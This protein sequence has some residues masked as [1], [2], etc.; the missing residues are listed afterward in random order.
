MT[1]LRIIPET[2]AIQF[3]GAKRW[4]GKV[5]NEHNWE[6]LNFTFRAANGG[7]HSMTLDFPQREKPILGGAEREDLIKHLKGMAAAHLE[8]GVLWV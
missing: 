7:G 3:S 4:S 1:R 2:E 8:D 5:I 6:V